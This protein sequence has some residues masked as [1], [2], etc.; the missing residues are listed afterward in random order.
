MA[1][2][3]PSDNSYANI[4][5]KNQALALF[6]SGHTVGVLVI[7]MRSVR[8]L[9]RWG[10]TKEKFSGLPVYR[11]SFPWGRFFIITGQ[12]IAKFLTL[13]FFKR[14]KKDFGVPN[15]IHAHFG[16]M[17]II[18]AE[19]KKKFNAP[20][21]ITEHGSIMLPEKANLKRKRRVVSEGYKKCDALIA[22]SSSLAHHIEAMGINSIHVL[23]NIIPDYFFSKISSNRQKKKQF[24]SVGN[25]VTNKK[26][27][28]T[29]SA[30]ARACKV[31]NDLS[32]III[33]V[34]PEHKR[35]LNLVREKNI[36]DRVIFMGY[37]PNTKLPELYHNSICFILLSAYETFGVAYAEALACGIP[38]IAT[39]CGG[40]EDILNSSN[41]LIIP[42]N[43]E[44][45]A[46]NSILNICNNFEAYNSIFI[47]EDIN[48]RFSEN[49]FIGRISD[50]YETILNKV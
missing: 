32:L 45:A 28:I 39:K 34:G 40:P 29:I 48:T 27:D 31:Y 4:F 46:F 20:L 43:D 14:I 2:G 38:V 12:K 9:R 15:I 24:I 49:T 42:V 23:P 3:F 11:I 47:Q 19:L 26:F 50:I 1:D 10:Y 16:E 17:G 41:G 44:E 22:V 33:G 35:L 37:V 7:D 13:I 21:V 8:R 5:I 30:F 25:L 36:E 18:G 6:N